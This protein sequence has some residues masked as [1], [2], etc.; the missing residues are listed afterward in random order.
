[1]QIFSDNRTAITSYSASAI[2]RIYFFT[3]STH[4]TPY[5]AILQQYTDVLPHD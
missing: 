3:V 4:L 5:P 2:L 1:M